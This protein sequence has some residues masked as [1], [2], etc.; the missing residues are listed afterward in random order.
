MRP[1]A[2]LFALLLGSAPIASAAPGVPMLA[3]LPLSALSG[4]PLPAE[5]L[6]GKV[7]LFVNVA[8]RCGFTPQYTGLE[9]L[10]RSRK[11]QGLVLVGVPCNQFGA[12]E[13]GSAAEI[14]QFCSLTYGVDFPLLAKQ[15]VNGAGR[16]PL[17][18]YLVGSAAG[19]GKDIGW[20]FEKFLV[21]RDGAVRGRFNSKVAPDAP[22]LLAAIDAA[23]AE[24]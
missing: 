5:A 21:G 4:A 17:Y 8:S 10:Y 20:N 9:A 13:P 23:L 7:V 2:V 14:Q 22:A 3:N 15:D 24:K 12:Q 16:S 1:V 6:A 11:D 18:D 19:G